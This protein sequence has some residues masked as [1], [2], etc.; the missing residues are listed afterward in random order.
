MF[1]TKQDPKQVIDKILASFIGYFGIPKAILNDNGGEYTAAELREVKRI[2]N[3]VD[4]TTE[5]ESLFENGHCE[6]N[7]AII[8]SMLERMVEDYLGGS[9]TVIFSW[10]NM[11]KNSMQM[12]FGYNSNQ[13][14]FWV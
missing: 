6:M 8:D 11:A 7:H 9:E 12:V 4:L 13:I 14:V 1:I 3:M 2:I 10:A 5:A